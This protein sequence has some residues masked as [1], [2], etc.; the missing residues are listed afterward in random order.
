MFEEIETKK[1][2]SVAGTILGIFV[3]LA[4]IAGVCCSLYLELY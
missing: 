1:K 4:A 3:L 2:R